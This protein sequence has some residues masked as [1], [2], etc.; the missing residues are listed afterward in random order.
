MI[1][2]T[3]ND[4]ITAKNHM[5]KG[6]PQPSQ[7]TSITTTKQTSPDVP[8]GEINNKHTLQWWSTMS[9]G[10]VKESVCAPITIPLCPYNAPSVSYNKSLIGEMKITITNQ[11]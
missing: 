7:N 4:I 6:A 8:K 2:Y 11:L 1:K 5:I 10:N 3:K 9:Q